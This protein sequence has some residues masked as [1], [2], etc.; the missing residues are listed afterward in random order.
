MNVLHK[1]TSLEQTEWKTG[2]K[3]YTLKM[4]CTNVNKNLNFERN[5]DNERGKPSAEGR[6]SLGNVFGFCFFTHLCSF[7]IVLSSNLTKNNIISLLMR[8]KFLEF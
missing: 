7:H 5:L 3:M 6:K 4:F 2:D 1:V 8:H